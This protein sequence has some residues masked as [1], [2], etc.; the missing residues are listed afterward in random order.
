MVKIASFK[1]K[2]IYFH[3]DSTSLCGFLRRSLSGPIFEGRFDEKRRK[4]IYIPL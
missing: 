1:G 3:S 4:R 2:I